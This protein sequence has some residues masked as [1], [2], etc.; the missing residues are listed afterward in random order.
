LL[1]SLIFSGCK[2]QEV[3]KDKNKKNT[4]STLISDHQPKEDIKVNK[5][6]G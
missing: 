4:D 1:C 2:G 3:K 6:Y 5:E